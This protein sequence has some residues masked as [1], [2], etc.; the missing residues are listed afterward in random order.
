MINM[1]ISEKQ[2]TMEAHQEAIERERVKMSVHHQAELESKERQ[3][4][5]H[6]EQQKKQLERETNHLEE[7]LKQQQELRDALDRV[8]Q[9][10]I[11]LTEF[12]EGGLKQRDADLRRREMEMLKRE[13]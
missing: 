7:Q 4:Q 6:L 13:R 10:T 8:Q 3:H 11:D 9:R 1:L 2:K 12:V 5:I